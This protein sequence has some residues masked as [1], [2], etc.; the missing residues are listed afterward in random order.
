MDTLRASG[1][2][3]WSCAG[4]TL[5]SALISAT[6]ASLALGMV[7]TGHQHEY[8]LYAASRSIALVLATLFAI[9]RRSWGGVAATAVAMTVV[10]L[11]DT[12]VGFLI[13]NP[14]QAYGPLLFTVINAA[15]LLWMGRAARP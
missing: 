14:G 9:S 11:L 7:G 5:F 13:H 4:F 15:L 10:Q 8:A 3:F 6:F 1:K 12:I 2:A